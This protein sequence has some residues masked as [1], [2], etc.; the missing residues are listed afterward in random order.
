MYNFRGRY[1]PLITP[2]KSRAGSAAI[3]LVSHTLLTPGGNSGGTTPAI[4]TTGA[5][6]I[7]LSIATSVGRTPTSF[8]SDSKSNTYTLSTNSAAGSNQNSWLYYCLNPT[9]GSGHTFTYS[10]ST[11]LE[12]MCVA[13]FSGVKASA[14]TDQINHNQGTG[15]TLAPGSI[16]PSAA[17][18][19]IV[20]SLATALVGSSVSID[21]G[22]TVTDYSPLIASNAYGAGLAYLV[23]GAAAA[24][25]PTW[26]VNTSVTLAG[27]IANFK[28]A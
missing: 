26:T 20:T 23:Q 11:A 5:N 9:V 14:A 15:T 10:E 17:S 12:N 8:I 4:V 1:L 22:F 6:L 19:L 18:S 28:S 3:A 27:C 7:V 24:I 13:A 16:T 25:N 2:A 21:T